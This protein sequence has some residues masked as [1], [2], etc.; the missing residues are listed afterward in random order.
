MNAHVVPA[1]AE[2][3]QLARNEADMA[4]T[5]APMKESTFYDVSKPR[6]LLSAAFMTELLIQFVLASSYVDNDSDLIL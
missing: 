3:F 5:V 6:F 4:V 2:L 1:S